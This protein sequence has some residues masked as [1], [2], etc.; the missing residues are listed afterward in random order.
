MAD[1]VQSEIKEYAKVIYHAYLEGYDNYLDTSFDNTH[2]LIS[3]IGEIYLS[4]KINNE[5]YTLK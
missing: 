2:N 5:M 3:I 4:G 1:Q